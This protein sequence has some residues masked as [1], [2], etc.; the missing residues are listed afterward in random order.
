MKKRKHCIQCGKPRDGDN[1]LW[2]IEC[3]KKRIARI[4]GQFEEIAHSYGIKAPWE[5]EQETPK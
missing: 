1:P 3:D 5:A 4:S 2:C